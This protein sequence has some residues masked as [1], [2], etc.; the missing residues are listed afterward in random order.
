M[1]RRTQISAI[2]SEST[3]QMLEDVSSERGLKKTFIVENALR[4]YL[5]GLQELPDY[6]IIPPVLVVDARSGRKIARMLKKPPRPTAALRRLM[7]SDGD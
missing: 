2:V 4:H 3:K 7:T 5:Q 1:A 6:A